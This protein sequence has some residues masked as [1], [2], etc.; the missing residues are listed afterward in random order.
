[1]SAPKL[2]AAHDAIK[3]LRAID[4]DAILAECS[5]RQTRMRALGWDGN[6]PAKDAEIV[7]TLRDALAKVESLWGTT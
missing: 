1:M 4:F 2:F 6:G 5:E 7:I 3:A